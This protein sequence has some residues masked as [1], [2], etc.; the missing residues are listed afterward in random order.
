MNSKKMVS[1][2]LCMLLFISIIPTITNTTKAT[3]NPEPIMLDTEYIWNWTKKLANITYDVYPPDEYSRGRSLGSKG[4]EY[5]KD[6]LFHEMNQNLS[7][8]DVHTEQLQHIEGKNRNYTNIFNI[9]DFQ[10]TINNLNQN[11]PYPFVNPIPKKEMFIIASMFSYPNNNKYWTEN[12]ILSNIAIKPFDLTKIYPFAG[13]YKE[14]HIS[15]SAYQFISDYRFFFV[16][17]VS[18][19]TPEDPIPIPDEQLYNVYMLDDISSSQDI[20]NNLTSPA[21]V[22]IVDTGDSGIQNIE[23]SQCNFSVVSISNANGNVIK[24]LLNDDEVVLVDNIHNLGLSLTFT[25]NLEEG[26]WPDSNFF[27]IDRIPDHKELWSYNTFP[28]YFEHL[29]YKGLIFFG[30]LAHKFAPRIQ[31]YEFSPNIGAY[32]TC[33]VFKSEVFKALGKVPGRENK[34]C[35]GIILYD[36]NDCHYMLACP[37][38]TAVMPFITVNNSVGKFLSDH[39]DDFTISGYFNQ[40]YMNETAEQPYGAIGYNIMGN[41]TAEGNS[42][43]PIIVLSNRYDGM[44]GQTPGDAGGSAGILLGIMK[45]FKDN[46]IKPKY[47]IQF[48]FT[49][50]EENGFLGAKYFN[51]SHSYTIKDWL[52]LEQL[53]FKQSDAALC[54]HYSNSADQ[55]I[56]NTILNDSHYHDRTGYD[57]LSFQGN[58]AGSEQGVASTKTDHT[59]C[60]G[61]DQDYRWDGWHRTG[62]NYTKGDCLDNTDRNDQNVSAE[63]VW[64]VSKYYTVDPDCEFVGSVTY[65]A[66]DSPY[67][68][69]SDDDSINATFTL[70][71]VLPSDKIRV[72]ATM[73]SWPSNNIIF[74]KNFDFVITSTTT[75]KTITVTLPPAITGATGGNYFLTLGLLNSTGRINDIAFN[76]RSYNDTDNQI[77]YYSLSPRNTLTPNKPWDITFTEPMNYT[78]NATDNNLDQLQYQWVWHTYLYD[79]NLSDDIDYAGP[80]DSGENCTIQHSYIFSGLNEIKVRARDDY[81]YLFDGSPLGWNRYGDWSEWSEPFST[82]QLLLTDFDMSCTVLSSALNARS[83]NELPS[84]QQMNSIYNALAYGGTEPLTYLWTFNERYAVRN[85]NKTAEYNFTDTG[86]YRVTLNITD[87]NGNSNEFSVNVSVVNLS[88]SFN[89]SVPSAFVEPNENITFTDTSAVASGYSMTNW[90]WNFGDGTISYDRNVTHAFTDVGI[91]NVSLTVSD[92]QSHSNVSVQPLLVY[93]DE[94]PPEICQVNDET[95]IRNRWLEVMIVGSFND[96]DSGSGIDYAKVN[97]TNPNG[98]HANYTMNHFVDDIYWYVFN[99]TNT[100]GQYNYTT[101]VID[102]ENNSNSST[103]Y[104]FNMPTSP[105]LLYM[106]ST[107]ANN[108]SSNRNWVNVNITVLDPMNTSAFIDWDHS[109]KGYW[110]MESYNDTGVYDNST[111]GNFGTFQNEMSTRN[112]IPG[113]YG[114]GLEFDGSDDYLDVGTSDS[115]DLGTGDFTFMVWEKSHTTQYSKK[116]MILTNNPASESWKGYGFGVMNNPYLIVSQSTGN[117]ITLQGTTDV[118]DNTWHHI[119]YVCRSGHYY[120]YVDGEEDADTWALHA[121]NI[122]NA[123]HTMIAYD[124][125]WSSWC[126]FEG[127]FDEPQLYN[128]ALDWEEINASYNNGINRLSHNFTDLPDGTYSYYAHAIDTTGNQSYT[129]TRQILIDTTPPTITDVTASPHTVGFGYNVTITADV[130]DNGSSVDLVTVQITPPGGV[131]N[132]SNNTMTLVSNNTYQYVFTD[133]WLTGQYNYTI[134]ATD[135]TNNTASS[136]GHHFHVSAQTTISIATLKN[137]YSG[138]QYI[139]ITDPPNPPENLTLVGR[140][141]TWNTYYNASSGEN[142]L[143]T[144]QGPVNYQEENGTWTPINNTLIPLAS[145]HPAYVYGYRNGNDHGLYGVYFKSNAQQD[146]PV[147]FT[148]NKSDDPTIH[149]VRSKLVGVGYVD[150]QSNWAYQYLQN[151]QSSQGQVSDYSITYPGVFT[152][153]NVIWSYGNTGLKEEITLSNATKTVLQNHPP[154]QYDLNDASSYLV[155]ITK[156]D[157]QN[158]NLYNDSGVLDGNVTI[159]ENGVEFKDLLGQFKCTLPLGEAYELNNESNRE[160]LT[161]RIVHLNGNTYLLSG[162]KISNLNEMTFPV[163]IDPTLTVYSISSDGHIYNSGTS[164]TTVHAASTGTVDGSGAYITIGQKKIFPGTYYIYRGFVFF[165]TSTLPSNAYLDDAT[166]SLYKKDDYSTT[167]FDITIQN[168]Q[169]TYPRNPMQSADYNK[170]YYSGNGGTLSTSGFTSGYNAIRMNN[171]S[172]INKTGITKLCLRSSRDISGT[173]PTGNEYVN[174][175]SSEFLGMCPPKL[176]INYRNQSKIKNTGSTNIKGYLL[177]QVQFYNSSQAKWVLDN[178][179]INESTPRIISASGSGSGSQLGL[180]TIFNGHVRASDLTHGTGTYRVFTAFRDPDGNI[181]KTNTGVE[182]KAW[183]QF[184]K[185]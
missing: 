163:V 144:Y 169:P 131:G 2:F 137:S 24:D 154:S 77:G 140:G 185:T 28:F 65:T 23:A 90:T 150:P 171:L 183:W 34:Q 105:A 180:D 14:D 110:P 126:Y 81:G 39:H 139:N 63:L 93:L 85:E 125:H 166:L 86:N 177:I 8:E 26:W 45:Y 176:V 20:L 145:N 22:I 168:G 123:Q 114:D 40:W 83:A 84:V 37:T 157:Y 152:G 119:A 78:T 54:V 107:P 61:K 128:R 43:S 76:T 148:Y 100:P 53:T 56:I 143:E 11:N 31:P 103:G 52:I 15:R 49:T 30:N 98:A 79:L 7:L 38:Y 96:T 127:A 122:T 115:L 109:L 108:T 1:I 102:Y 136:S 55:K 13:T 6:I 91:Y 111:Y 64:N 120:I 75:E 149:A 124:G 117:N 129:E 51:D 87:A 182:L 161:Y 121:K 155:F 95:H 46:D 74:W 4:G 167:D 59:F 174:V 160:T 82:N 32:F 21:A 69:G 68:S 73:K 60:I 141:L 25:Y 72:N 50:G 92:N 33:A 151:V 158:L 48:L 9:T 97:I 62:D 134:W 57:N 172:W 164:Y 138:T 94:T 80:F 181:L 170:N 5:A 67:D 118:T 89:L 36:T 146:W 88:A 16:G 27:L 35:L 106:N 112:I 173:E 116:A 175:H 71:S 133:T 142:I 12:K 159:S 41:L 147:A 18:Y 10:L 179:T 19:L 178:D 130:V 44:W 184:S 135:D 165:N 104:S 47:N 66:V 29:F 17:I 162:L 99:D 58:G 3:S 113:K 42:E 101:W 153:T 70:K 132:S 156:L